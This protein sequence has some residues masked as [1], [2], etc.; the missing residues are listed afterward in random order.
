VT[1]IIKTRRVKFSSGPFALIRSHPAVL[2]ACLSLAAATGSPPVAHG[3]SAQTVGLICT[4]TNAS[5]GYT[6]FSAL[7]YTNTYLIDIDGQI[8]H[9]WRAS[10]VAANTHYLRENGNLVRTADPG[11]T[12]FVIGGDA[13]AVQEFDWDGNL[14]WEFFYND[15]NVRSHHDIALLPNSNILMIAWEKKTMAEAVAAGRDLL[16]RRGN[17]QAYQRGSAV[18]QK[19]YRQYGVHWIATGLPGAG[20]I[21]VFNNGPRP[22]GAFSTADEFVPPVDAFGVYTLPA[23]G[24]A[25]GPVTQAW[26]YTATPATNLFSGGLSGADRQSN[27]NTLIC[28]GR[29]GDFQEVTVASNLVWQYIN[30]VNNM[31]PMDQGVVPSGNI[32]FR[33]DRYPPIILYLRAGI[34]PP[35]ARWSWIPPPSSNSRLPPDRIPRCS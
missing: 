17:P 22:A 16:Y 20:N 35:T 7:T 23:A 26:V 19:L 3:A 13:G 21:L 9:V 10:L 18:D 15:E 2:I 25:F 34:S 28:E 4:T 1:L 27:G 11:S 12:H 5:P 33:A 30:P 6:L 29:S 14:L 31:G 32:T 24:M 8:V